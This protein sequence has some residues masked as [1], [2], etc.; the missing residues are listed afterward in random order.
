MQPAMRCPLNGFDSL[1]FSRSAMSTGMRDSAHSMRKRPLSASLRSA[2]L[3]F[4]VIVG[5]PGKSYL[6][7]RI[8]RY[9]YAR[10]PALSTARD[11]LNG[12]GRAV[13]DDVS[14]ATGLARARLL[15][16]SRG[17]RARPHDRAVARGG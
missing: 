5:P 10:S 16:G 13:R 14:P 12:R 17:R 9:V 15:G 8:R 3:K 11:M 1:Y 6:R 4:D 2:T 7:I